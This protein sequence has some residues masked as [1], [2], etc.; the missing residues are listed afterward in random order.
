M[1]I[2]GILADDL[3]AA[4]ECL[5]VAGNTPRSAAVVR[6]DAL[7][8]F[9]AILGA[10]RRALERAVLP[11]L[12]RS[13]GM[14]PEVQDAYAALARAQEE[15]AA[16]AAGD[17]HGDRWFRRFA[18]LADGWEGTAAKQTGALLPAIRALDPRD[19]AEVSRA[20]A[21]VRLGRPADGA[22]ARP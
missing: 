16:L 14:T 15:G 11:A 7:G 21:D 5:A 1:D 18:V 10:D 8:R 19:R 2:L 3:Q 17:P 9:A 13:G 20:A 6:A 12:R 4:R 22:T